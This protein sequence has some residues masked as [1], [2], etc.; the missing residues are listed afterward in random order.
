MIC[1]FDWKPIKRRKNRGDVLVSNLSAAFSTN[2]RWAYGLTGCGGR[3]SVHNYIFQPVSKWLVLHLLLIELD[4]QAGSWSVHVPAYWNNPVIGPGNRSECLHDSGALSTG[5]IHWRYL[6]RI[7]THTL[8]FTLCH[9][10][11]PKWFNSAL[12]Q[13]LLIKERRLH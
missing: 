1:Y 8:R 9:E 12:M 11:L 7:K 5:R 13:K 3:S 4:P 6:I 2:Y 10:V